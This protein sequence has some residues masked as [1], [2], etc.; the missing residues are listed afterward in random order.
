MANVLELQERRLSLQE[1]LTNIVNQA[2]TRSLEDNENSRLAEIRNE[3]DSI[4]EQ[5]AEIEKENRQIEL[6]NQNN[7]KE[8]KMEKQIRLYDL[9]KAVAEGNVTDE[10]RQYVSG[11]KINYRTDIQA[12]VATAG[13]EVVPEE[14]KD[15]MVAIRNASV[16]NKL[17]C[18]WFGNAVG[19]ISIPRY[20]GSIVG[21]KGEIE[22]ADNGEGTFDEVLLTPHRLTAVLHVSKQFLAQTSEDAEGI[23]IRDLAEAISEK[24]DKTAFSADSGT[25]NIPE[26]LFYAS[27]YTTTGETLSGVNYNSVLDL[28]YGIEKK[29]G[30]DFVFVANPRVKYHLKGTQ[31]GSGLQMVYDRNEIDGYKAIVSNSVVDGGIMALVP[32]DLAVAVWDG[33]EITV[34]P[35]TRADYGEIR[36]VVN[37]YV[38]FK[39]RGD[40]FAGAIFSAE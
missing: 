22:K 23:L 18:T 24:V 17:G 21:W 1:E 13:Q 8:N 31:M 40:R 4:D 29:N 3:I 27:G 39:R 10:M 25:T 19:D 38:D 5:I 26:G 33:L 30:T 12:G 15:L 20:S 14:K 28:E 11:Q 16:L 32:R 9:I 34:D 6:N 36:L 7:K 2:E 37:Y 35:Y